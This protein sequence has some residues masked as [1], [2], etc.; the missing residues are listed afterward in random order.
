MKILSI[1]GTRPQFVKPWCHT[2]ELSA[3]ATG[4]RKSPRTEHLHDLT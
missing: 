3:G 2:D 1:V 4:A